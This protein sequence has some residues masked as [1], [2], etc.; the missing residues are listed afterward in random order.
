M[1][2]QSSYLINLKM[3]HQK[4]D[5]IHLTKEINEASNPVKSETELSISA[6][7]DVFLGSQKQTLR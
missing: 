6:I 7:V 5:K 3:L 1:K 4:N 2:K